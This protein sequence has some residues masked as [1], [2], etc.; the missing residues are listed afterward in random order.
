LVVALLLCRLVLGEFAHAV[1]AHAQPDTQSMA[2]ADHCEEHGSA[3]S[4]GDSSHGMHHDDR[5]MDGSQPHSPCCKS[6][7]CECPGMHAPALALSVADVF[8]VTRS[9]ERLLDHSIGADRP[10]IANLFRPP[11]R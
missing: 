4:T 7:Q 2:L 3:G 6:G 1:P 9:K 5:A 8:P 11:I 10:A